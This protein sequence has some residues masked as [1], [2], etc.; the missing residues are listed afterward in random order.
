MLYFENVQQRND[1][2]IS[3]QENKPDDSREIWIPN[4]AQKETPSFQ[5][6]HAAESIAH[7][8]SYW[9]YLQIKHFILFL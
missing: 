9:A 5:R 6:R 4:I 1:I 2:I 7:T 8:K 3:N